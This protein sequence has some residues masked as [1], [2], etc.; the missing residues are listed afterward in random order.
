MSRGSFTYLG[1]GDLMPPVETKDFLQRLNMVSL[2]SFEMASV[3]RPGF[4]TK[5]KNRN[6]HGIIDS[7]F[8]GN[9][10]IMIVEY[11]V[12]EAAEGGRCHIDAMIDLM[13]NHNRLLE[14]FRGR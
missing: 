14:C 12:R 4:A 13:R 5:E 3:Q 2:E 11:T 7:N 8:S 10:Q 1:V 9:G 6:T